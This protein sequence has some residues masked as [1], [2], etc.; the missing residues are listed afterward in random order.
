VE[1][2][3]LILLSCSRDKRGGGERFDQAVRCV[4]STQ[5]LPEEGPPL[6]DRRKKT[7]AL[8]QGAP[9]RLY[10]DDQKGGF[11]DE[12]GCNRKLALGPDFGSTDTGERVYLPAWK[13]YAGRFFSRLQE[14]SPEFWN[15]IRDQPVEVLFVSGLYGLVLWDELI[16]EYDCH[17]SDHTRDRRKQTVAEIWGDTLTDALRE[18]VGN[19]ARHKPIRHIYELLSESAYQRLFNWREIA[20][21]GVQVY[22]RIFK[23]LAG[24]D[25]LPK[26]ATILA[27]QRSAFCGASRRFKYDQWYELPGDRQSPVRFGFES[28]IGRKIDATREGELGEAK[29]RVLEDFPCLRTVPDALDALALAEHSWE[30]VR[31]LDTFD[32][33]AIIVS[34][35]KAVECY[36]QRVMPQCP[37]GATL[38]QIKKHVAGT[39]GW[40]AFE[41][42]LHQL[43]WLRRGGAHPAGR[44][45]REHAELARDSARGI[46]KRSEQVKPTG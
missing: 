18:F 3:S 2:R 13:R 26:L 9:P 45:T 17:F 21:S 31:R 4:Y 32:F 16:Q 42:P 46:F 12:R 6:V 23:G 43:A 20:P 33:G 39:E 38:G 30:K 10:D 5:F 1:P 29:S 27:K 37:S 40:S 8:L 34:F 14:E 19:Q 41:L 25:V 36:L 28:E 44:R 15:T 7:L 22:H 35:A 24:P 11:R